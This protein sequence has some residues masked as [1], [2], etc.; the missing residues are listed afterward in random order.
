MDSGE[1][2]DICKQNNITPIFKGGDQ[3][4]P[5]NYRPV[6]LTSQLT[7][8]FEKIVRKAIV[9]HLGDN[10]LFNPS[11]QGFREGGDPALT[12]C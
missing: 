3:G 7:K 12:M 11:Q 8:V 10:D 2:M 4:D 1:T 5:A 9:K 6:S